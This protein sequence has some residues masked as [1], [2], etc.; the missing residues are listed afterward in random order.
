MGQLMIKCPITGELVPTGITMDKTS[1]ES[2]TFAN[3]S[4]KCP[5]CGKIHT[6]SKK[7]VSFLFS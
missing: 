1:F 2:S 7:D 5:S 4:I 6:W 3:N